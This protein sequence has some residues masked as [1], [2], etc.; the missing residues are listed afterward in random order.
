[1]NTIKKIQTKKIEFIN[2]KKYYEKTIPDQ[3]IDEVFEKNKD[4]YS[5]IVKAFKYAELTPSNII[6]SDEYN[7]NFFNKLNEIEN[8]ILDGVSLDQL[9]LE[10]NLGIKNTELIKKIMF[11]SN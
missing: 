3:K 7:E 1:M 6:G 11:L 10:Y 5:E 8:K 9:V 2:L 4:F